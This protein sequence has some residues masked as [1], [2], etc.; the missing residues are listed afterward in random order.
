MVVFCE[1]DSSMAVLEGILESRRE[2]W[3]RNGVDGGR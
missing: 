3:V 2:D 1:G